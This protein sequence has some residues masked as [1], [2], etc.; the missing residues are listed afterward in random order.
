MTMPNQPSEW[1]LRWQHLL[2][3]RSR[4][5]DLACGAGRHLRHFAALGHQLTGVDKNA[6]ALAPLH[7]IGELICADLED[8]AWPLAGRTFAAVIVTN[9]LWRAHWPQLRAC[10]A[11]GGVLLYET[12]AHGNAAYGHPARPEFLLQPGE[13]LQ[14]CDGWHIVAYEHGLV[15]TSGAQRVVQRIAA[16]RPAEDT[17]APLVRSLAPT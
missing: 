13:L 4:V 17:S 11:P 16:I 7:G 14:L 2:A 8:A 6:A 10:V 9:Y 5:L 12:F 15:P 3:P 1:L